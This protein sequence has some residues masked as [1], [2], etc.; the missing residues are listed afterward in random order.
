MHEEVEHNLE[1][2]II[3]EDNQKKKLEIDI[4]GRDGN[5]II[6]Y[7]CKDTKE[8]SDWKDFENIPYLAEKFDK[9]RPIT[10]RHL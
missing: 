9:S 8:K 4:I 6:I 10:Q 3:L 2:E 7:E 5:D 1:I